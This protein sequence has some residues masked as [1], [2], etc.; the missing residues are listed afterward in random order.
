MGSPR[1]S[2]CSPASPS[3]PSSPCKAPRPSP[4]PSPTWATPPS[5]SCR[6]RPSGAQPTRSWPP[7]TYDSHFASLVAA[8][9]T[10]V[11][12]DEVPLDA[13]TFA[14]VG[15]SGYVAGRVPLA[16]GVHQLVG[17]RARRADAPR[18]REVH[19]LPRPGWP[20]PAGD[21][22]P[23]AAGSASRPSR[24][25]APVSP[26]FGATT[27]EPC[28]IAP[29][30]ITFCD[31]ARALTGVVGS[32]RLEKSGTIASRSVTSAMNRRRPPHGR[33]AHERNA[34]ASPWRSSADDGA[35]G[36]GGV[37]SSVLTRLRR[38]RW[39]ASCGWLASCMRR[40]IGGCP[41][42]GKARK[43][44]VCGPRRRSP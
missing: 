44:H 25:G 33:R 7:S 31:R 16:A 32:L 8:S 9:G 27:F 3:W 18:L 22:R 5:G 20:R 23:S 40:F 21:L 29:R 43:G 39:R 4:D 19:E 42:S 12:L 2:P 28:R 14:P 35:G 17:L 13:A 26:G 15:A 38:A 10:T 11:T 37:G 1:T 36:P 41:H 34:R 6:Q 24:A 30:R